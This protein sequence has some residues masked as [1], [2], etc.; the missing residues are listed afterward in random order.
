MGLKPI[1]IYKILQMKVKV[2]FFSTSSPRELTERFL[3]PS[4]PTATFHWES[5]SIFIFDSNIFS[6]KSSSIHV[7]FEV[8]SPSKWIHII[9]HLS[10]L[11][12][13][14]IRW[15]FEFK[16]KLVFQ[17]KQRVLQSFSK[18]DFM[19]L[20]KNFNNLSL[21]KDFECVAIYRCCCGRF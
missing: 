10:S 1:Y 4:S 5:S 13:E 8:E 19:F 15:V 6:E 20:F 12:C 21:K 17:L 7:H 16:F 11:N 9:T 2:F 3:H 18:Q 14:L